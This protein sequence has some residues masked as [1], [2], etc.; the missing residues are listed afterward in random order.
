MAVALAQHKTK[1]AYMRELSITATG[2]IHPITSGVGAVELK[3]VGT[4]DR[5]HFQ[6]GDDSLLSGSVSDHVKNYNDGLVERSV[7]AVSS[8]DTSATYTV[9]LDGT[10]FDY[11]A[12][13]GDDE[14]AIATALAALIDADDDY[15]AEVDGDDLTV[16][17]VD[18]SGLTVASSATG[19]GAWSQ[20]DGDAMAHDALD[21][22]DG[23][24]Q[25]YVG[26]DTHL[27][28]RCE[29]AGSATVLMRPLLAGDV[30]TV[31]RR[32]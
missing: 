26:P 25:L 20:T 23:W 29:N 2:S 1:R 3:I 22:D 8:L 12:S 30:A 6:S 19:T 28:L 4:G 17:R 21:D 13:G 27:A 32:S 31:H 10:D 15:V 18:G 5:V 16:Y 14:A 7:L 24:L 9:T 11:A